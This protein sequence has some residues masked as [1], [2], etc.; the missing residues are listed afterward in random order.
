MSVLGHDDRQ[1]VP[2][3]SMS[4]W[5][6]ICALRITAANGAE[7]FG[8]GFLVSPHAVVTAAHNIFD[9][10]RGGQCIG[11]VV[12]P[13]LDGATEQFGHQEMAD[14]HLPSMW[15][16]SPT[17]GT[18][19]AVLTLDAAVQA[20]ALPCVQ[21]T[22]QVAPKTP[23]TIAGYPFDLDGATRQYFHQRIGK[24]SG[25]TLKY[26][27][28]TNRGQ[29]GSPIIAA[30]PVPMAIGVHVE[31]TDAMNFGVRFTS[32]AITNIKAWALL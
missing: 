19:Y 1:L 3:T 29:S 13:A 14:S 2:D 23:L 7:V 27:I 26:D 12:I 4:P 17:P 10:C 24:T 28:D 21:L 5:R 18:D 15:K 31:G 20:G 11:I 9:H 25:D 22:D 16:G 8:T 6:T 32:P 30:I